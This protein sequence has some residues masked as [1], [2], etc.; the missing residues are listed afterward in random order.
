MQV[1]RFQES[2]NFLYCWI[3]C[4]EGGNETLYSDCS[5]ALG[6]T[7]SK[8]TT[9]FLKL[10]DR[11]NL[12]KPTQSVI[13]ICEETEKCFERLL[14]ATS[15]NLPHGKGIVDAV[16]VS[17]LGACNNSSLFKELEYHM[18]DTT[19]EENHIRTLI[20][21]IIKCYCKVRLYHLGKEATE[22]LC[23][24]KIRTKLHKLVLFNHQQRNLTSMVTNNAKIKA[25]YL[26]YTGCP[27]KSGVLV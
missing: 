18:F 5:S 4:Q 2:F 8:P 17:V 12:Y 19:V 11:G 15:G 27:K 21:S 13:D 22:N 14:V 20:K 24:D 9:R 10:K 25:L 1:I 7:T 26:D 6:L 3:R 16:A 23:G